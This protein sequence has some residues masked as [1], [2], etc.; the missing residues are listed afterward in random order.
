MD[1]GSQ[2]AAGVEQGA[3]APR[4]PVRSALSLLRYRTFRSLRHRNYRLYFAGQLVS[5]T[6]S[7][8]QSAALMWLV[9]DLTADPLW[10]PLLL[11]AQVGPTLLLGPLGGAIADRLSKRRVVI[12]TQAAFMTTAGLLTVLV[13]ADL[14]TPGLVLAVSVVNGVI[15][16]I[17]L[18]VRL[19]FVPDLVARDDLINAVGLN[20]LLFNSARAVGPA[21]AG[22]LF[23]AAGQVAA[24]LPGATRPVTLGAAWC[25]LLNTLS[26]AAVLAA[27][28]RIDLPGE[29][30]TG[31]PPA[32]SAWD[33]V[34]Y[35]AA[36][37]PLGGLVVLT[38]F[39]CVFAWPTLTLLPAYTQF[40]LGLKA[41]AYSGL[42]S[43][44]GAGALLAAV[45]TATFGTEARRGRFL[46]AGAAGGLAGLVGLANVHTFPAALACC[47]AMG[48]GLILY[49]STGQSTLQ[50]AVPDA[51]RG[52]VMALWAMTLSA[53]AP[54][55][56]L[57]AGVA[58]QQFPVP[59]VLAVMAGG[60]AVTAGGLLGLLR[61]GLARK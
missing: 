16:G 37:P 58:A 52:R 36:H 28:R 33:G 60:V 41:A 13:A 26:Y 14:A 55:G 53:S 54:V 34:R 23:L 18:P 46:L 61:V 59:A 42:V 4:S 11:A 30:R 19:A 25:F 56:H 45:A 32:G 21:V 17:D 57:L 47:V 38:G 24:V 31:P 10:P 27:L 8:M 44:L 9:F 39:F 40:V 5:F 1:D 43:G 7:W 51:T 3:D 2:S 48:F 22:V 15:Q 50:L 35:L 6:G 49:L 12:A 20:S 29:R